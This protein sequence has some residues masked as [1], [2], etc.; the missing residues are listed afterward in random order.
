MKEYR[1]KPVIAEKRGDFYRVQDGTGKQW[2][3]PAETFE[4][5]YEEV[6]TC[7]REG[8]P[9]DGDVT[10]S[11]DTAGDAGHSATAKRGR[12]L[13]HSEEPRQ[14]PAAAEGVYDENEK[15]G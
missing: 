15:E 9:A 12:T 8:S 6:E 10:E 5:M 7:T 3:V 4:E 13:R 1:R 11:L 2:D 14:R